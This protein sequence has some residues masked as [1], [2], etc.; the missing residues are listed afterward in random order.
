LTEV[1]E[2]G[3]PRLQQNHELGENLHSLHHTSTEQA[4]ENSLLLFD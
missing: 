2:H 1:S 4:N 3:A